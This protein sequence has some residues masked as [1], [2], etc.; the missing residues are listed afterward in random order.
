MI[1][2]ADYAFFRSFLKVRSGFAL[3]DDKHYLL[4][5]RLAPVA[6]SVGLRTLSQ[7]V[8]R[9]KQPADH[10]TKQAVIE[11]MTTNE[12]L[13]FRDKVPFDAFLGV[14]LPKLHATR[15][16]GRDIRVWCAAAST[17][18]EPY[19]LAMLA[20]DNAAR[21]PGRKLQ[22]VAT[23]IS[24]EALGR[25]REGIYTQFE[26]QRGLPA[27]CLVKHFTK[28]GDNWQISD[29]LRRN[30]TFK[31]FN[32]LD[33]PVGLGTFDVVFCRNV[34]IYFDLATKVSVFNRLDS[35]LANDG[36]VILGGAESV[37]GITDRFKPSPDHRALYVRT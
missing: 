22:I 34:L 7:L 18:Q 9:L 20:A 17:G 32:L 30:I 23:D 21:I 26:V 24:S 15:P 8:E 25:A 28:V 4:E 13:F 1:S 5:S 36:Y 29:Q 10:E 2:A 37:L 33:S 31:E 6:R 27:Q 3:P 35:V 16:P 19:S 14:A 12:S 11:A